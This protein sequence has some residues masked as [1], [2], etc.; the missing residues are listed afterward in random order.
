M[1]SD[2][3]KKTLNFNKMKINLTAEQKGIYKAFLG[4]ELKSSLEELE[5]FHHGGPFLFHKIFQMFGKNLVPQGNRLAFTIDENKVATLKDGWVTLG[6]RGENPSL[7]SSVKFFDTSFYPHTAESQVFPKMSVSVGYNYNGNHH[8][9]Y[10]AHNSQAII[11][12]DW[13]PIVSI[14][15]PK[16]EGWAGRN[17]QF[18]YQFLSVQMI[19]KIILPVSNFLT[20]KFDTYKAR[21]EFTNSFKQSAVV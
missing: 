17:T 16:F 14:S 4:Y 18:D 13:T 3:V 7:G 15:G 8:D 5:C 19:E 1:T 6:N 12:E 21:E 10:L 11:K 2:M 9:T 20:K